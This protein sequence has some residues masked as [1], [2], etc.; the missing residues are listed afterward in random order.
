MKK[1]S[2]ILIVGLLISNLSVPFITNAS[3]V[4]QT[5]NTMEKSSTEK[6]R[7]KK[8]VIRHQVKTLK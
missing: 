5:D 6:K 4:S 1:I 7:M 3:S 2:F 8:K